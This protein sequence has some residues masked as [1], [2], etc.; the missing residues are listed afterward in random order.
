MSYKLA[1]AVVLGSGTMGAAIAAHLANCG[2]RVRLLDILPAELTAREQA[3]GLS[4]DA[5]QVRNRI[6]REGLER[7]YKSRPASFFSSDQ[8]EL[9]AIGNLQDDLGAVTEADWVIE[10]IIEDLAVKR[11]LMERVDALRGPST[12]VSTNT[13]GIPV[14][15]IAEGRSPGFKSH[16]L[17]THFFNPPRYL[18]LLEIVPGTETAPEVLA[19]IEEIGRRRLGKGLVRCK[20]TPN[21]IANRLGSVSSAF[22]L[23]YVLENGYS[24]KEVDTIIGPAIGRPKT[25][26]FRLLDLVGIDVWMHI[27]RNLAAAVPDDPVAQSV[28]NSPAVQSLLGKMLERGWLGNKTGQGF[29]KVV[30][31][32][33]EKEFWELNLQSLEY[34]PPSK[35]R[36]ESVGR[37]LKVDELAD[38]FQIMLGAED[39]AGDLVRATAFHGLAYASQMIPEIADTPKPIDDAMRWGFSHQ[40]GPFELWDMLGVEET[41]RQM[42][43][44]GFEPAAWVQD[45]RDGGHD[46]FY[47]SLNGGQQVYDPAGGSYLPMKPAARQVLFQQKRDAH[48]PLE[49]NPS[50]SL[51]DLGDGVAGMELHAKLNTLDEDVG[52]M[53]ETALQT[54][55]A[56]FDGLVISTDA[57]NFSAGA[58]L[59]ILVMNAQAGQFEQIDAMVRGLQELHT[60]MR[61]F[62][63]PVVIAPA[64][65]ALAGG[66]EMIMHASRIVAAAELYTGLVEVGAGVIPA[67]GGVK[68]MLR[69]VVNPVMRIPNAQALAIHQKLFEQ[70]GQAQVATSAAQARQYGILSPADRVVMNR[71]ELLFEAKQEVLRLH[72]SAYAPPPPERIYAAG[73]DTLNALRVALHMFR[74]AGQI[75]EYE[76][77]LG[78]KLA[79]VMSGGELSKPEWVPE[80]YI[81]E[82]E[83]EAFLSLCGEEKTQQRMWHILNTGKPL[84]N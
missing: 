83:R 73:R 19:F 41:A 25:G 65:L 69:R 56:E 76:V 40:A 51:F 58:N 12:I 39:R 80:E 60:T 68:E 32:E 59:F 42:R 48:A 15:A 82:L 33:G 26:V 70:I 9:V 52:R 34:E 21:F 75:S 43:A 45:M 31:K 36:F 77:H 5:P 53:L 8:H 2:V 18:K 38:R 10:A 23:Q 74:E 72:D 35:P 28:L 84:R 27:A 66:C 79:Y 16:F 13:S 44:A 14:Q 17:G 47:R 29:Y 30:R 20:D 64:G 7:A 62:H 1:N 57:D 54:V 4:L 67:G 6:A 78:E 3:A 55:D 49:S 46:R 50:A 71:E 61:Y 11:A 37:A 24:V 63:K 22:L 81:L